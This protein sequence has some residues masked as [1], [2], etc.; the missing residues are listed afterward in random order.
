MPC[1]NNP[2]YRTLRVAGSVTFRH[3]RR[4]DRT[5]RGAGSFGVPPLSSPWAYRE[6]REACEPSGPSCVSV[7]ASCARGPDDP[8]VNPIGGGLGRLPTMPPIGFS[9]AWKGSSYQQTGPAASTATTTDTTAPKTQTTSITTPRLSAFS[10]RW[11]ALWAP[12]NL[13]PRSHRHQTGEMASLEPRHAGDTPTTS[14]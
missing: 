2:G 1:Q 3:R 13:K 5:Q 12:R 6:R 9:C 4:G 8:H 7:N 14:L 10:P 11:S